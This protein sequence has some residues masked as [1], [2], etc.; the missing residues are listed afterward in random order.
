MPKDLLIGFDFDKTKLIMGPETGNSVAEFKAWIEKYPAAVIAITGHTDFIGT[1]EYNLKL[2]QERADLV[3]E[4][5]VSKGIPSEK[6]I[7]SSAGE[8]KPLADHVTSAG[9]AKN[10]STEV[11]IKK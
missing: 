2:G 10:R 5:L 11:T 7:T 8:D 9:R 3:K 1:P 4:Y 6:I